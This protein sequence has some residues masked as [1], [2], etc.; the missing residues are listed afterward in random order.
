MNLAKEMVK[1]RLFLLPN[2]W[3]ALKEL[4]LKYLSR[5]CAVDTNDTLLIGHRPWIAPENYAISVFTPAKKV[6]VS[7]FKGRKIPKA[8][9][10]FLL[11]SNGLFAFDLSLY[12]LPPSMQE[13]PPRLGRSKLQC[14]DLL[15]ANENWIRE[16]EVSETSFHFGGRAY[17]EDENIG[18]FFSEE[19]V[20]QAIRYN[21]KKVAEWITMSDFLADELS[22]AE[23]SAVS[24]T[25]TEWWE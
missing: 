13:T 2:D 12:G 22:A 5:C 16:F 3:A 20:I 9:Q 8:Y 21:G 1:E 6:W 17:T 15:S 4:G 18:Y 14:H 23:Q 11:I 25:P 7:K 10:D 19:S 24:E